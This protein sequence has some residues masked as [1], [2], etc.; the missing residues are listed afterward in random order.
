MKRLFV[1]AALAPALYFGSITLASAQEMYL[2]EVRLFG[3]NFCPT[4]WVQASG[5]LLAISPNTALFSLYG[6]IYGGNGTTN[7]QLPNLNGRAPYGSGSP[8]GQPIGALYGSSTTTLTIANL[9][10]HTHQLNATSVAPSIDNPAGGFLGTFTNASQKIYA[11][12]GSPANVPMAPG[13][14]GPTG[15][16]QP[17]STQSPALSMMWCVAMTGIYPSRQ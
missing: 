8:G 7:F 2:G 6:T 11:A 13:A 9:P 16:S 17:F 5:Q 12:S 10:A 15:G 3:F 1:A 4:G 14:I